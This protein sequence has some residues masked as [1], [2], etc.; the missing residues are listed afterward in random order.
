MVRNRI[1]VCRKYCE[2]LMVFV[3]IIHLDAI[4]GVLSLIMGVKIVV[5]KC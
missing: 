1:D 2:Y 3:P 5:W 4:S